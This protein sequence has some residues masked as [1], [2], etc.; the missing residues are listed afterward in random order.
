MCCRQLGADADD[1][2]SQD[3]RR[4]NLEP[5]LHPVHAETH[6]R[7]RGEGNGPTLARAFVY[8]HRSTC[9]AKGP[10]LASVE[11]RT[12]ETGIALM[13]SEEGKAAATTVAALATPPAA[14]RPGAAL[15]AAGN[16]A[17]RLVSI[18]RRISQWGHKGFHLPL[19]TQGCV[20]KQSVCE[21]E[22]TGC[23]TRNG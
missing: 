1:T 7:P 5:R 2:T 16:R 22:S 11:P 15:A 20:K 4:C 21:K 13:W 12:M 10:T 18:G 17:R 9:C 6:A 14:K 23:V 19:Q 3:R 8:T